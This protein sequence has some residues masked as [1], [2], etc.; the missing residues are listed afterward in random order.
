MKP[1]L[2]GKLATLFKSLCESW[3]Y[4]CKTFGIN[5]YFEVYFICGLR[6]YQQGDKN[7]I[8]HLKKMYALRFLQSDLHV[9]TPL[10]E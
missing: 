1:V 2:Q 6:N 10:A 3:F 8:K 4:I 5:R 9:Q 7:L